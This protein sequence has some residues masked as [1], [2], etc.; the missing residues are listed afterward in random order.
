MLVS[1]TIIEE[2]EAMRKSGLVSLAFYYYDFRDDQK[3]DL[4]GLLSSVLFQLCDQS[5]SYYDILSG[6]YSAHGHGEQSPSDDDLSR[7]LKE[8]LELP[9]RVP[10]YLIVD[11]LDEC[12]NTP[13]PFPP[14]EKVLIL[15]E[16]LVNSRFP[17]LHVCVTS[18]P[19]LDIKVVV[20]PL[21]FHSVSIHDEIGQLVDIENY[22]K[23]TVNTDGKM[24]KW[25]AEDKQ[26]VIDAL[27]DRADGM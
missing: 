2:I 3:K 14:R 4:R 6:F 21:T 25:K 22:I 5:D 8:L 24:R 11:A 16:D 23:M 1:S 20:Q 18:R 12:R 26:L 19:E 17:N 13:A 15:V 27:T 10:V 7:C 9:G